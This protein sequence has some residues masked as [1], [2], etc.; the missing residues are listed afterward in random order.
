ME[1]IKV[2][3]NFWQVYN[4]TFYL[5]IFIYLHLEGNGCLWIFKYAAS[6]ILYTIKLGIL[7]N[8]TLESLGDN[9]WVNLNCWIDWIHQ[10][11]MIPLEDILRSQR[12]K[13]SL[14]YHYQ[15]GFT[16]NVYEMIWS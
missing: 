9:T 6:L 7:S 3:G 5:I 10:A 1:N 15:N 2:L 16:K 4:I 11:G 14:L 8:Y 12:N 13:F